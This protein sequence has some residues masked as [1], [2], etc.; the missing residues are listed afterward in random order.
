MPNVAGPQASIVVV[1]DLARNTA[2]GFEQRTG[3]AFTRPQS[4]LARNFSDR[5]QVEKDLI[6]CFCH[7]ALWYRVR[8]DLNASL[9]H[10]PMYTCPP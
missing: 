2:Q 7:D 10:A 8:V 6:M 9:S 3:H 1:K 4:V 5:L